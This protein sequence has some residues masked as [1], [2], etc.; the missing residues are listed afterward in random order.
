M[1]LI[2]VPLLG[3]ELYHSL[4]CRCMTLTKLSNVWNKT[5]DAH[6]FF[7][8]FLTGPKLA[9]SLYPLGPHETHWKKKSQGRVSGRQAEVPVWCTLAAGM[10]WFSPQQ[11]LSLLVG[12]L[13]MEEHRNLPPSP[14]GAEGG[15]QHPLPTLCSTAAVHSPRCPC[16]T[17]QAFPRQHPQLGATRMGPTHTAC[18]PLV[19]FPSPQPGSPIQAPKAPSAWV[20]HQSCFPHGS[21]DLPQLPRDLE[22][23][24]TQC[25][26]PIPAG[27][28]SSTPGSQ[29]YIPERTFGSV[30]F[31]GI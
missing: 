13:P 6:L 9:S 27:R 16:H 12:R 14:H 24:Y 10:G 20:P 11:P 18:S 2:A 31:S 7:Q 22:H 26:L 4:F 8:G 17:Q 19:S 25:F 5:Q 28:A 1:S 3:L 21:A 30:P 29:P 23:P 15:G